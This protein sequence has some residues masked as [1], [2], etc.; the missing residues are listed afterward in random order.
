M[1]VGL[2]CDLGVQPSTFEWELDKVDL[3][4]FH[5]HF[6]RRSSGDTQGVHFGIHTG[7]VHTHDQD[8]DA[9]EFASAQAHSHAEATHDQHQEHG[10]TAEHG[11]HCRTA[12]ELRAA[13]AGSELPEPVKE[14]A[15]TVFDHFVA[16]ESTAI[17]TDVPALAF[18]QEGGLAACA[19]IVC[20]CVGLA[21]LGVGQIDT[22][23]AA[24][25]P[26][27]AAILAGFHGPRDAVPSEA[28]ETKIG[29]GIGRGGTLHGVL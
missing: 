19:Q 20:A 9:G 18:D 1:L 27:A 5:L 12:A 16:A 8:A 14:R 26:V 11:D 22:S 6:D 29:Y 2:L 3:G 17:H 25:E 23:K 4:A 10:H 15:L 24:H 7:S 13:V 28:R 21:E